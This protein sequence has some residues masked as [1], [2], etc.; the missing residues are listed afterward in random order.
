MLILFDV[1]SFRSTI[2]AIYGVIALANDLLHEMSC[3][4][5]G[6]LPLAGVSIAAI[7]AGE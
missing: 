6:R 7:A 3:G 4:G 1:G 2:G 5:L